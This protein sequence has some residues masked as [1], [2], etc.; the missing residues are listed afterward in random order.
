MDT[1]N[2]LRGTAGAQ[3]SGAGKPWL[4][5]SQVFLEIPG[6]LSFHICKWG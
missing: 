1:D 5:S 2:V 3:A 6:S 4:S